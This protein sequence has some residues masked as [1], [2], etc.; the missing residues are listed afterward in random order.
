MIVCLAVEEKGTARHLPDECV[1][2]MLHLIETDTTRTSTAAEAVPLNP[3]TR[4]Q[5]RELLSILKRPDVLSE[6]LVRARCSLFA[7]ATGSHSVLCAF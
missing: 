1:R 3:E 7:V 6:P 5:I 4:T 2:V